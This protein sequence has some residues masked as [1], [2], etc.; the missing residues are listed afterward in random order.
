MSKKRWT[1]HSVGAV[2]VIWALWYVFQP[3]AHIPLYDANLVR[4]A[5]TELQGWCAGDTFW[6]S[7]GAGNAAEAADCRARNEVGYSTE[8]DLTRVQSTFCGAIV[9]G[10]W[11]G[12]KQEC[13]DILNEQEL[14]P[15]YDGALSNQWNR[16]RPY[17][18]STIVTV[19][20]STQKSRTGGHVGTGRDTMRR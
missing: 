17:P 14:W 7:Q 15:T 3:V 12:K 4:L 13:I 2:V 8:V 5:E 9:S 19:G 18:V 16:A 11:P 6:K 20:D 1:V 10:G